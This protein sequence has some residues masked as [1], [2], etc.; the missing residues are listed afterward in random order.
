MKSDPVIASPSYGRWV[1]R[2]G[3]RA[4]LLRTPHTQVDDV[5]GLVRWPD[6]LEEVAF[7]D[8]RVAVGLARRRRLGLT[9]RMR[10]PGRRPA[11]AA[12]ERGAIS[13]T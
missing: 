8:A 10:S 7:E 6:G 5:V 11:W 4:A 1:D 2:A 9:S 13:R 12:G 3:E